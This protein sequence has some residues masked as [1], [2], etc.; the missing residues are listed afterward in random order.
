MQIGDLVKEKYVTE[1]LGIVVAIR[2]NRCR[3][4]F[5]DGDSQWNNTYHFWEMTNESR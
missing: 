3:V 5:M 4:V 2:N 1:R